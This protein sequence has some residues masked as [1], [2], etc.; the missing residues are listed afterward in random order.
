MV[1][2]PDEG[3]NQLVKRSLKELF[4][5]EYQRANALGGLQFQPRIEDPY[6]LQKP[7]QAKK[8]ARQCQILQLYYEQNQKPKAISRKLGVK[9]A[10]VNQCLYCYKRKVKKMEGASQA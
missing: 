3:E 4:K 10:E 5:T 2:S 9:V 8:L 7:Y 6:L 1:N